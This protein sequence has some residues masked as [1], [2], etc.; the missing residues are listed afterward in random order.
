MKEKASH[1]RRH[2]SAKINTFFT[3][4]GSFNTL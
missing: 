4:F 1:Q 3:R 2:A